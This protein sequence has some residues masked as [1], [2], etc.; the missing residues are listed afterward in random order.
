MS[1]QKTPSCSIER[2]KLLIDDLWRVGTWL[3]ITLFENSRR[4]PWKNRHALVGK[5]CGVWRFPL[6]HVSEWYEDIYMANRDASFP[7]SGSEFK[8]HIISFLSLVKLSAAHSQQYFKR[9]SMEWLLGE[10]PKRKHGYSSHCSPEKAIST[11]KLLTIINNRVIRPRGKIAWALVNYNQSS[12]L[13]PS[14]SASPPI[15]L[16]TP[17]V[18]SRSCDITCLYRSIKNKE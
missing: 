17:A 18:R 5:S 2:A 9:T 1:S 7:F 4:N 8:K 3:S 11:F 16:S 10:E 6:K 13:F 15:Q 12:F 14:F